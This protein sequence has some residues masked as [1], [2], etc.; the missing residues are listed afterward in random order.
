MSGLAHK[1]VRLAPI[2]TNLGLF[3]IC[4]STFWHPAPKCTKVNLKRCPRCVL[5][6]PT[7]GVEGRGGGVVINVASRNVT[8]RKGKMCN[9][10]YGNSCFRYFFCNEN[11]NIV[12]TVETYIIFVFL[13]I[14]E[15]RLNLYNINKI[16]ILCR[17]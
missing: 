12:V 8:E 15:L 7:S 11:I 13:K 14:S 3:K 2:G 1:W 4:Y 16:H 5:L 10:I 9:N 6:P 17:R